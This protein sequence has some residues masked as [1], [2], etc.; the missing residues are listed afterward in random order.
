MRVIL[1][2]D[3]RPRKIIFI[4]DGAQTRGAQQEGHA[5]YGW[6]ESDPTRGQDPNKMAARKNQNVAFYRA[7]APDHVFSARTYLG[8]RFASRAAVAKQFPLRPLR[9][10][11]DR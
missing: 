7:Y 9:A 2:P 1:Q 10:Y 11:F 8:R 3:Y 4:A 5:V 6:F